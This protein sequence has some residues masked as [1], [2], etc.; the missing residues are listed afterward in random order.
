[1]NEPQKQWLTD[2]GEI[3]QSLLAD[4]AKARHM[5]NDLGKTLD[6]L[7]AKSS[8]RLALINSLMESR[9]KSTKEINK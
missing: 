8:F 9:N 2:E 6:Q 1:M 7:K 5:L 4:E 3:L